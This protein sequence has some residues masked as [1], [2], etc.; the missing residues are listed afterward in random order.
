VSAV[1][2]APQ[3]HLRPMVEN[4]LAQVIAIE[5]R[6]Y[7]FPWTLGIFRDCLRFG[8]IAMVYENDQGIVGY[9]ILSIAAGECHL[10]NICID[11]RFQGRG[12]G[13]SLVTR[14]L[15][16]ARTQNAGVAFLEVR[17]SNRAAYDMYSK[18]GFNEMGV[19]KNYYPTR[20]GREDA[21]LLARE[22]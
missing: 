2:S 11:P 21:I 22:L 9:G 12:Y 14:L 20:G 8:Y 17:T 10:L 4:D 3:P 1:V 19:R 6:A 7:E 16:V 13:T 15:D 18:L 5:I